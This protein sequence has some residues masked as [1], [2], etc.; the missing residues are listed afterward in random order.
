MEFVDVVFPINL[1]PLTYKCPEHLRE[2]AAPGMLVSAPLKNRIT[3]GII[4]GKS[5]KPESA[6][7]KAIT[8]IP[9]ELP[10]LEPS[11][12]KLLDWMSDY[13]IA[14][15]GVVLKNMLPREA[16]KKVKS[17]KS[18]NPLPPHPPLTKGGQ[19]GGERWD[20]G[21]LQIEENILSRIDES[22]S[23]KEYK[24]FLVHAPSSSYET[25][26]AAKLIEKKKNAIILVPEIVQITHIEPFIREVAGERLCV[27]HSGLSKG[28]RSDAFKKIIAGE[29]S[30][31]LGTRM[32][33][34]AP[35]KNV[36]LI[37]VMQEHS[38][39]YKTEEGLRYNARDVAVMRGYL[40]KST[41]VLSSICP[42]IESFHNAKQNKYSLLKPDAIIQKP[43]I[44][45]VDM[46]NEKQPSPN[47][48]KPVIEAA[49]SSI[50]KNEKIMLVMNRKG[51]SML[52][53]KECNYTETC[54]KCHIP[55]A[56]YKEDKSLR[57]H[58]CGFK[59][60]LPEKC[61]RCNSFNVELAGTGIQRVEEN[62]KKLFGID[63]IR[64]DSDRI[65]R[66][67]DNLSDTIKGETIIL[68]TK[69]LT[70]RLQGHEG[71]E[72][73]AVL[74]ADSYLNQPDF[75]S[76]EK[77]Y[78]ELAT[79]ADK[80][81]PDGRVFIQT[82]MSQNYLFKFIRNYDYAG[83][84]EEELKRRKE[85]SYPPYS[86]LAI[87]TLKGKD[88]NEGKV[89]EVIKKMD[90]LEILGPSLS[91]TKKGQKE[92]T[93]LLKSPSKEKLHTA[94]RGILK[95]AEGRKDLKISVAIDA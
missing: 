84:S 92:Y 73:A 6:T 45:I 51:Y 1:T 35:L 42:S 3:T 31:V 2:K 26:L 90:D 95:M 67:S 27:L 77:A 44:R 39:S 16:F 24:T 88:Y 37:A 64:F 91:L 54:A 85:M 82:R 94:A 20:E 59:S 13:Y 50:K 89:S 66:K 49:A 41:V 22:I 38:S 46:R 43:R 70:K 34:F 10:L 62:L 4:L 69:L 55:L 60:S 23:K 80:V 79:I 63:A 87:I 30:V 14:N 28:A 78:Q 12:L 57:C 33:V 81:K 93:L 5:S 11:M 86:K 83:F 76:A 36:S 68:G 17:R 47:L 58:Y 18:S 56:F 71:F 72:I 25:L 74:N 19:R 7:I 32:A 65:K 21:E 40:E 15:K 29:C 61:R 53:C 48:S 52:T 9:S 8:D 75:R